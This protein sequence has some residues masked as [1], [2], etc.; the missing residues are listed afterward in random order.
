MKSI[1]LTFIANGES[2]A[3]FIR[4]L[5]SRSDNS[6]NRPGIEVQCSAV[7]C[8]RPGKRR[9][10]HERRSWEI[11]IIWGILGG[12]HSTYSKF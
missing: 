12:N 6:E 10:R 3:K 5:V 7:Q 2:E 11:F 8:S 9:E 4:I 1:G